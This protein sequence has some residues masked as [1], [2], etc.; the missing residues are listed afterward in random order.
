[1]GF[2]IA[3][4]VLLLTSLL[5]YLSIQQ[6]AYYTNRVEHTYRVL[7]H[8]TNLRTQI[9]DAQ[10]AIRGYLLLSDQS[11]L[12]NYDSLL[13]GIRRDFE[14]LRHLTFDN[15]DHQRRL[16]TLGGLLSQEVLLL[17]SW[18]P[19]PAR[20]DSGHSGAHQELGRPVAA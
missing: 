3:L 9:R 18:R 8:T 5:A 11:Y 15:P 7:Q 20:A 14:S 1:L 17:D 12:E 2:G 6:V 16:D 10:G 13:G 4:V 19:A